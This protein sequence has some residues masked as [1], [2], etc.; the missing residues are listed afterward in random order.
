MLSAVYGSAI[1]DDFRGAP[2]TTTGYGD[3]PTV[4][5]RGKLFG[6]ELTG[7]RVTPVRSP[8]SISIWSASR[9]TTA[10]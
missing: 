2:V 7:E 8:I 9:R 5:Y 4:A 3:V 1:A 10:P 6:Y